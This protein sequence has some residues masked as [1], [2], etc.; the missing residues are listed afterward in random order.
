MCATNLITKP[1]Q[2]NLHTQHMK[3]KVRE[4]NELQNFKKSCFKTYNSS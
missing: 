3:V 2:K 1:L 4:I